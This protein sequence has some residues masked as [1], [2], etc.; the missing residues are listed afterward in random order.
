MCTISL[1]DARPFFEKALAHGVAHGLLAPERLEALCAE[2]PKGMVQIARYFGSEFLRPELEQARAR[3][4]N[5]ISLY[6]E[7]SSGGDL[8][9]AAEALLAGQPTSHT[10]RVHGL[11][12]DDF[13]AA[14]RL[15]RLFYGLSGLTYRYGIAHPRAT[16][17]AVRVDGSVQT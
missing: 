7:H 13:E 9:L 4:V 16:P 14:R 2:A 3:L 12:A 10:A 17:L 6:L 5:L 11:L 1:F 15:A 8:R